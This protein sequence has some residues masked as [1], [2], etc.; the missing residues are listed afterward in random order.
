[1]V[2]EFGVTLTLACQQHPE[3]KLITW[4]PESIDRQIET[5]IPEMQLTDEM[6]K[7]K[8]KKEEFNLTLTK[9]PDAIFGL[10]SSRGQAFFIL[11]GKGP[12]LRCVFPSP[13]REGTYPT[14]SSAGIF[15]AVAG[16]L[17]AVQ[18]TEAIKFVTGIG[19]CL[20]GRMLTYDALGMHWHQVNISKDENCR[21]CGERGKGLES[22][23]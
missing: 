18:A 17:G 21:V 1:M 5:V 23:G 3:L 13:P 2:A 14:G 4:L 22:R 15:G 10:E 9:K 11:P 20:I 6:R 7:W 12:C 19:E 8:K 16:V